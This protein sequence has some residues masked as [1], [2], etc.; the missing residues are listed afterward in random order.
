M[1]PHLQRRLEQLLERHHEVGLLL[2]EP[3][4]AADPKR[5]RDLSREYAQ[6]HALAEAFATSTKNTGELAHARAMLADPDLR[7][8]AR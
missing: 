5:F 4:A 8:L 6:A 7:E 3:D 1:N 2:A